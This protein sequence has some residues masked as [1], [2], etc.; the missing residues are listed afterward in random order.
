MPN[1]PKFFRQVAVCALSLTLFAL[2]SKSKDQLSKPVER[3]TI[4]HA[5]NGFGQENT[6]INANGIRIEY[7]IAGLNLICKKPAYQITWFNPQAKTVMKESIAE[8]RARTNQPPNE[9][10]MSSMPQSAVIFAGVR[11]T[12]IV[13]K[14]SNDPNRFALPEFSTRSSTPSKLTKSYFYVLK[15]VSPNANLTKFLNTFFHFPGSGGGVPLALTHDRTDGTKLTDF[16]VERVER[17]V[18]FPA[19]VFDVPNGFKTVYT[20]PDV[21][22]GPGYKR[23]FDDLARDMGLGVPLGK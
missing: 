18:V 13:L 6:Y 5:R 17:D 7:P 9:R 4:L 12:R 11:A 19:G 16:Q 21:A 22:Q 23:Q 2:P 3:G 14:S 1:P 8:F 20:Q 10:D 15:D